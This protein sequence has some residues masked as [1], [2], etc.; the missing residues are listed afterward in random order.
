MVCYG[1]V[2]ILNTDSVTCIYVNAFKCCYRLRSV[3]IPI[4]VDF[5]GANPFAECSSLSD[6]M[7]VVN[8]NASKWLMELCMT[9][10]V[11]FGFRRKG[12]IRSPRNSH[13]HRPLSIHSNQE[14][15]ISLSPRNSAGCNAFGDCT[16]LE[17]IVIPDSVSSIAD[18]RS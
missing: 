14:T 16:R 15:E 6:L 17:E 2:S 11:S 3:I 9:G 1:F 5:M 7:F 8:I 10:N 13:Y 12:S 4:S 18:L